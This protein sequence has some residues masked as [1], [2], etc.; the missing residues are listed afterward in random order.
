MRAATK[1]AVWGQLV[2][3]CLTGGWKD[4]IRSYSIRYLKSQVNKLHL[5]PHMNMLRSDVCNDLEPTSANYINYSPADIS[6]LV[7]L[8]VYRI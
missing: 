3:I 5:L 1:E 4:G 7:I 8:D 6:F 2:I